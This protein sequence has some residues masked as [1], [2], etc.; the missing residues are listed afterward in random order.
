M[1][2]FICMSVGVCVCML[3][4][5]MYTSVV[6]CKQIFAHTK[7]EYKNLRVFDLHRL[8]TSRIN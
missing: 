2:V 8:A 1:Y 3:F 5:D 6:L 4:E 7:K